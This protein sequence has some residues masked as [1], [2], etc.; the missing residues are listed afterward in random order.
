MIS[1]EAGEFESQLPRSQ[2]RVF[3]C[4]ADDLTLIP[5]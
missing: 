3:S 1:G 5:E 2:Q 4:R